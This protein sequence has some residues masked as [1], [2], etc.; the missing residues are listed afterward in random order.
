MACVLCTAIT[1]GFSGGLITT[2]V[3]I[4]FVGSPGVPGG[5]M[6]TWLTC[7]GPLRHK[8]NTIL[9]STYNVSGTEII[10]PK[11]R[12]RPC[13]IVPY[14]RYYAI[15]TYMYDNQQKLCQPI[16]GD[17]PFVNQTVLYIDSSNTCIEY[18]EEQKEIVITSIVIG[19]VGFIIMLITIII[20]IIMCKQNEQNYRNDGGIRHIVPIQQPVFIYP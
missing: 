20:G 8:F 15:Y 4:T 12:S 17:P 2:G 6:D 5:C 7:Y 9:N 10:C 13:N 1:L 16:L 3:L 18:T 11:S 14:N 19:A